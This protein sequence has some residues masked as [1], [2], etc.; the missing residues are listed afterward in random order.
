MGVRGIIDRS[1]VRLICTTDDP[2]DTLEW[3]EKIAADPTCRVKVLPAFRPDKAMAVD[4]PGFGA[5]IE[6]LSAA[7]GYPIDSFAA[8]GGR[9]L[10]V[11]RTLRRT[12]A[13][14][15]TTVLRTVSTKRR[16]S[17]N[18]TI[19]LPA[20]LRALLDVLTASAFKRRFYSPSRRSTQNA[21]G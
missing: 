4:K 9:F 11:S 18:S 8:P 12:A 21:A 16:R 3:H 10:N 20:R 19:S 17:L 5:Y 14:P 15:A 2:A 13:A 7:V 1:N 6:K